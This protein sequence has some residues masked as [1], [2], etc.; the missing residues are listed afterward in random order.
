MSEHNGAEHKGS[1]PQTFQVTNPQP[2]GSGTKQIPE[3]KRSD[4]GLSVPGRRK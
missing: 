2:S 1:N 3:I 4:D